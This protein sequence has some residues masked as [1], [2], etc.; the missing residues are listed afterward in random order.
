MCYGVKNIN[1]ITVFTDAKSVIN[2]IER[3]WSLVPEIDKV[4]SRISYRIRLFKNNRIDFY[5][6]YIPRNNN[7]ADNICSG[8]EVAEFSW[9]IFKEKE[10]QKRIKRKLKPIIHAQALYSFKP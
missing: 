10:Q 8:R 3:S 5:L 1:S 4:L 6:K 9:N 2:L 7:P